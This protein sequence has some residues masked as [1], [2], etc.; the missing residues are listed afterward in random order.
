MIAIKFSPIYEDRISIYLKNSEIKNS[1][2]T[3]DFKDCPLNQDQRLC[4]WLFTIPH[5]K[6][7]NKLM[8]HLVEMKQI[9]GI[10]DLQF[11]Y[12]YNE[13][14]FYAQYSEYGSIIWFHI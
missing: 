14:E 1:G 7:N 4:Y 9:M 6:L 2:I 13:K 10:H 3:Y 11:C 12:C 8:S 5:N